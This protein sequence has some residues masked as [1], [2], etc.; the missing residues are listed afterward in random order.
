MKFKEIFLILTLVFSVNYSVLS[1]ELTIDDCRKMARKNYPAIARFDILENIKNFNLKNAGSTYFPQ[2]YLSGKTTYQSEVAKVP[3]KLPGIEIPI[4]DKDQ[5]LFYAQLNQIIWDGGKIAAQK[6][7]IEANAEVERQKLETEIYS[8][9]ER[10]N[11]VF[12]GILLL[13]EQ[14]KQ[15]DALEKE[16][17]H[18]REKVQNYIENGMANHTDLNVVKVEQLKARQQRNQ[19]ESAQDS[20]L[21]ILS[22]LI[23]QKV[24][25][26]TPFVKPSMDFI[27]VN[28]LIKRPELQLFEA[29]KQLLESQIIALN[30]RNRPAI[31]AFAQGG[32]GKP[33]LNLFENKFKPYFIGGL[34]FSWNLGS[35]YTYRNEKRSIQQQQK[36][37]DLQRETFLYNINLQLP[38]QQSE[39]EK[40]LKTMQDDDE[41]IRLRIQIKKAVETQVENGTSTIS[42]LLQEIN[43]LEFAKQAKS[44]HEIQY[45]MAIYALKHSIN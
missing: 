12:F 17:E 20:Y 8:L 26:Q 38:Q 16:L 45:L 35:L 36:A 21:K 2:L 30:A 24:N 19:L 29:Q 28:F 23:G 11:N 27:S 37:L 39:A 18:N 10:V 34:H 22:V 13:K 7:S 6:K 42:D 5:Y 1:Q 14:L 32:Y 15:Q 41:I 4:P 25:A 44:L 3:V 31:G 40:Y 33:T 9:Y 43:A